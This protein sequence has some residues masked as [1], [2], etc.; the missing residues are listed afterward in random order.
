MPHREFSKFFEE[1]IPN[2]PRFV[3]HWYILLSCQLSCAQGVVSSPLLSLPVS[4]QDS[5]STPVPGHSNPACSSQ[6]VHF[7]LLLGALIGGS[8]SNTNTAASNFGCNHSNITEHISPCI[9]NKQSVHWPFALRLGWSKA[10]SNL[11]P[12]KTTKICTSYFFPVQSKTCPPE[13]PTNT[14]YH[15]RAAKNKVLYKKRKFFLKLC[16]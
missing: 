4:L 14:Q 8:L 10:H 11:Q 6:A 9:E 16:L 7:H 5:L 13:T 1:N 12:S 15:R 2:L 3:L